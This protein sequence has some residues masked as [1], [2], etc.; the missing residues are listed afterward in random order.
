MLSNRNKQ[1]HFVSRWDRLTAQFRPPGWNHLRHIIRQSTARRQGALNSI[2]RPLIYIRLPN[3]SVRP[4]G[5]NICRQRNLFCT[6]KGRSFDRP[7][8]FRRGCLKGTRQMARRT[9]NGKCEA[10]RCDCV[11]R[12][13]RRRLHIAPCRNALPRTAHRSGRTLRDE[14]PRR[15]THPAK[16]THMSEKGRAGVHPARLARAPPVRQGRA[17]RSRKGWRPVR[18]GRSFRSCVDEDLGGQARP[19]KIVFSRSAGPSRPWPG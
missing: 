3:T 5:D 6:K 17:I 2:G 9:S 1:A 7:T 16:I 8:E 12:N 4:A 14:R 18:P 10:R 13:S 11:A 15:A 19:P